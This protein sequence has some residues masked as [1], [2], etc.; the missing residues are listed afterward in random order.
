MALSLSL[1]GWNPVNRMVSGSHP[2]VQ[3]RSSEAD[4]ILP[5]G[6]PP[7]IRSPRTSFSLITNVLLKPSEICAGLM[8]AGF[9]DTTS[10]FAGPFAVAGDVILQGVRTIT[11][12]H[13]PSGSEG[14]PFNPHQNECMEF[15]LPMKIEDGSPSILCPFAAYAAGIISYTSLQIWI[16]R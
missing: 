4:K 13:M 5:D 15:R 16:K 2:S 12:S 11:P 6:S 14:A 1:S 10:P 7:A 9:A 8:A 3:P